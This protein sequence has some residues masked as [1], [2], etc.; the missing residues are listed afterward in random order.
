[1]T[2]IPGI[3]VFSDLDGTLLGHDDYSWRPA[4]AALARLRDIGAGVILATSKTAAEVAPIRQAIGF[5]DWPAIVENGAGLLEAGQTSDL[6]PAQYN[7][8]RD[9]LRSLPVGFRGF[10]DMTAQEV[11]DVTG[12][13]LDAARNA[14]ARQFTEPGLWTGPEPE[15]NGFLDAA[16]RAGLHARRGGRFLTLSF[17]GTKADQMDAL[18]KRFR[19]GMTIALGDAPNDVEMLEKADFAVIVANSSARALPHLPGE[20]AGRI[21]RTRLEGPRGWADAMTTFLNRN[22]PAEDASKHG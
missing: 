21:L 4:A 14:K 22:T 3:L 19:P 2:K 9:L 6:G 20:V 16:R 11:A 5:A 12:L 15:L 8:I 13:S 17:G 1:M 18:I 7:E 10:G